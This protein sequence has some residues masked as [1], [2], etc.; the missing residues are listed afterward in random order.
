M[1]IYCSVVIVHYAQNDPEG[2]PL[3]RQ[4]NSMTRSEML[5]ECLSSLRQNTFYP[6]EVI[7][8]DNGG[9]DDDTDYLAEKVRDGTIN[10]LI[11]NKDN[12]HFAAAWNQG[13]RVASGQY[14][15]FTC[16]DIKF[17]DGWLATTI[18][19]LERYADRKL[20]GT[21]YI[22]PD[23]DKPNWWKEELP[24]GY[25][26]NSMAGSNCC[27]MRRKDFEILG[28]WPHHRIGGSIWYRRMVRMGYQVIVPARDYVEH[29]A[30][31]N[32]INWKRPVDIVKTLLRGEQIHFN[33]QTKP[34]LYFG[35]QDNVYG[36][37]QQIVRIPAP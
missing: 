33:Y 13:A 26:I 9:V 4:R 30:F 34:S 1:S 11:R 17:R 35:K 14:L 32:G 24:D 18:E 7:V 16:N 10:I 15:C 21:P 20:I 31:R 37:S 22:T 3:V 25:R 23:K 29:M 5:R 6:V 19:G 27:V 8:V 36:G 12:M 2:A 28:D